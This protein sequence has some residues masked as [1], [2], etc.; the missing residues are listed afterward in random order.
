LDKHWQGRTIAVTFRHTKPVTS[1]HRAP[2]AAR[3]ISAI[4]LRLGKFKPAVAS[5]L[6]SSI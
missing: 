2:D 4:A 1:A 5:P 6:D 3:A